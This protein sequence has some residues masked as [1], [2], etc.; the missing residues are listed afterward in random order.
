MGI[1]LNQT[2]NSFVNWASNAPRGD[3]S[4]VHAMALP[5]NGATAIAISDNSNDG[6][7]VF[8]WRRRDANTENMNNSTRDLFKQAVIDMFG[9]TID[10]VPKSVR[11]KMKLG[12]YGGGHPLSARR[13]LIVANAI[14]AARSAEKVGFKIGGEGPAAEGM[15]ELFDAKLAA[16]PGSKKEKMQT[17][18]S[19]ISTIAK[20]EFNRQFA[21]SMKSLGAGELDSTPFMKDHNRC[22]PT[23]L[24]FGNTVLS[25]G[26]TTPLDEK[27]SIIAKFASSG[28]TDRFEDLQ[29]AELKKAHVF[30][31]LSHQFLLRSLESGIKMGLSP[32]GD[33]TEDV[34]Q[35]G[36]H[37]DEDSSRFNVTLND[38]GSLSV[39]V[40]ELYD[41]PQISVYDE[42]GKE[43]S[44]LQFDEGATQTI[45]ADIKID[46][47]ELDSIC[48][49][50]YS[51]FDYK[52]VMDVRN[53]NDL[54]DPS[55]A[56]A[57]KMGEFR[58]GDGVGF[59]VG[60]SA[61]YTDCV[62]A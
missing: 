44:Y 56:S 13:I 30:M 35:F 11:D 39:H 29:G 10:D 36:G 8:A 58:F 34:L 50:D 62:V 43:V 41:Q 37:I 54:H 38:D 48:K 42:K 26:K 24:R 59:N 52:A 49:K 61:D 27:L 23:T 2:L 21:A 31:S 19:D 18:L 28:K 55:K 45:L 7:G 57:E 3:D 1:E 53:N 32:T 22:F 14:K 51:Q 60:F 16:I 33:T 9:T 5:S 46:S 6:I 20:N 12:D 47:K 40:E 15:K 4:L 25:Y 17:A